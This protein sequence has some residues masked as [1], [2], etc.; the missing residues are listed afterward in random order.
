MINPIEPARAGFILNRMKIKY[1]LFFF[2]LD[3]NL[4]KIK[5]SPARSPQVVGR[6]Y[7]K[8]R[9]HRRKLKQEKKTNQLLIM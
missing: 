4:V 1:V 9:Q 8:W 2:L 7:L 5:A 3:L 6:F